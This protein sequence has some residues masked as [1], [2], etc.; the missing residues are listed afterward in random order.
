[1]FWHFHCVSGLAG[2]G[3]IHPKITYGLKRG[4]KITQLNG[5]ND[6]STLTACLETTNNSRNF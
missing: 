3:A 6:S 5:K 4:E 2:F 1:M